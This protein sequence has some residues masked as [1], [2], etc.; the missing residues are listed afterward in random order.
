MA[1]I[2][3]TN[4]S[5]ITYAPLLPIVVKNSADIIAMQL[6]SNASLL[7]CAKNFLAVLITT[8]YK[9]YLLTPLP[10]VTG[11]AVHSQCG[12]NT[13]NVGPIVN[14]VERRGEGGCHSLDPNHWQQTTFSSPSPY[15][16][17]ILRNQL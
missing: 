5:I 17:C 11:K 2:S 16:D 4:K 6:R 15:G 14:V 9:N 1:W 7:G 12:V 10:S 13:S 8:G 3:C